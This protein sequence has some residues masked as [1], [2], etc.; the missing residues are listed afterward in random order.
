[1]LMSTVTISFGGICSSPLQRALE[2]GA[3]AALAFAIARVDWHVGWP[4]ICKPHTT[5]RVAELLADI[6][7]SVVVVP[8]V[9]PAE[10]APCAT[11]EDL[12]TARRVRCKANVSVLRRFSR[13]RWLWLDG[14]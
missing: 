5:I 9:V 14:V 2:D 10:G 4:R 12:D 1:M 3:F 6:C 8:P 11:L 13:K 7:R